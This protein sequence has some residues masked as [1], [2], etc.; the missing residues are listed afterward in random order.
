MCWWLCLFRSR[1]HLTSHTQTLRRWRFSLADIRATVI[2]G[3]AEWDSRSACRADAAAFVLLPDSRIIITLIAGEL[4]CTFPPQ[5]P[6]LPPPTP[7]HTHTQEFESSATSSKAGHQSRWSRQWKTEH[8]DNSSVRGCL[9]LASW[10]AV[11]RLSDAACRT[12]VPCLHASY[13]EKERKKEKKKLSEKESHYFVSQSISFTPTPT[14]V[15]SSFPSSFLV[16]PPQTHPHLSGHFNAG[17]LS[18]MH[19]CSHVGLLLDAVESVVLCH[20]GYT[21]L[22]HTHQSNGLY[23]SPSPCVFS[24]TNQ[25]G[26]GTQGQDK[27][28]IE[29]MVIEFVTVTS[30]ANG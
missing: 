24:E 29:I 8:M 13:S 14:P 23:V 28:K 9:A 12:D 10:T 17:G 25:F 20:H 2:T 3:T 16:S 4:A 26:G 1:L 27:K 6:Q 18:L 21:A 11:L 22:T 5:T 7:L 19:K 15:S 30:S